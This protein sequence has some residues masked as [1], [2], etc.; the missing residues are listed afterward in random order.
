MFEGS[1]VT[2]CDSFQ[3]KSLHEIKTELL[4][5]TSELGLF[6]SAGNPAF[7]QSRGGTAMKSDPHPKSEE[8]SMC[9]FLV[10]SSATLK[11]LAPKRPKDGYL[12]FAFI[13]GRVVKVIWDETIG[14]YV[15][16]LFRLHPRLVN[17]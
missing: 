12:A 13:G 17:A 15:E 11:R 4:K 14:S 16:P 2:L 1:V 10:Y 3:K 9:P 6:F 8:A 5:E 7:A